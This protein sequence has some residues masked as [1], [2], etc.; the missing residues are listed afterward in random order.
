[1]KPAA[2]KWALFIAVLAVAAAAYLFSGRMPAP[3][4]QQ[5]ETAIA[6][7]TGPRLTEPETRGE[8]APPALPPA[9]QIP[10]GAE[11][12]AA[13]AVPLPVLD[14][15]DGQIGNALVGLLGQEPVSGLLQ[16]RDFIRRVVVTVDNLPG[17]RLPLM[18]S[19]LRPAQG[20]F[21]VEPAGGVFIPGAAN[22]ARYTPYVRLAEAVDSGALVALYARFYPL[23]QAAYE[24]LGYP[25]ASFNVR[26]VAVIDHLLETPQPQEPLRLIQPKVRYVFEDPA[27]E[28]LSA[29]Q[30]ILLRMGAEDA[31]RIRAKLRDLRDRLAGSAA[32]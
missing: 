10:P 26:L 23:F 11:S 32:R 1:M 4:L 21:I 12:A 28:S 7:A 9:A 3:P 8:I 15:S 22:A 2:V 25:S 5:P 29:G 13:P 30:K 20:S 18:R 14:Q 17:E 24:E 19:P 16:V 27:L 31:A 6:P